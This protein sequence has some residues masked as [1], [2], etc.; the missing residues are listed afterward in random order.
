MSNR[1]TKRT[2]SDI[3]DYRIG[4]KKRREKQKKDPDTTV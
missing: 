3:S 2:T 1:K 4:R